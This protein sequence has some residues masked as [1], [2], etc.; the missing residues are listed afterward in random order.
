[1]A[2]LKDSERI[3]G[4]DVMRYLDAGNRQAQLAFSTDL[5]E[6]ISGVKDI[7]HHTNITRDQYEKSNHNG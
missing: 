6:H 7:L 3:G 5:P 2:V 4:N 1:M